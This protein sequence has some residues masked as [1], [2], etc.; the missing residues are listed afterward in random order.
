[1]K[2]TWDR[3]FNPPLLI[4][5]DASTGSTIFFPRRACHAM[6]H[7]HGMQQWPILARWSW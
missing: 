3:S 6:P 2:T 5:F 7:F 4:Y 1:M